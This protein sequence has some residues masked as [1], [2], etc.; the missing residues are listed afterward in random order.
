MRGYRYN[1]L[2]VIHRHLN[3]QDYTLA[4]IDD[5]ISRGG[6]SDW[7]SLRDAARADAGL[8]D[9]IRRVCDAHADDPAAQRHYFWSRHA[10]EAEARRTA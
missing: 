8:L 3:H 2:A 6:R 10:R 5:V 1:G 9:K 4:A 7:E